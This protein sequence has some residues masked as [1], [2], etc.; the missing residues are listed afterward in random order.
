MHFNAPV[1][2]QVR[3]KEIYLVPLPADRG[4]LWT[5]LSPLQ[6]TTL[7]KNSTS[8]FFPPSEISP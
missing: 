6:K 8:C 4:L 7:E 2:F 3:Y 5:L 1:H